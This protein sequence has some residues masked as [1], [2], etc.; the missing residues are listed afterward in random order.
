ME[1]EEWVVEEVLGKRVRK[2][3]QGVSNV[4]FVAQQSRH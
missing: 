3:G 4:L 2:T 1:E